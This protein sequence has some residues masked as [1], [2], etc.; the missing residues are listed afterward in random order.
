MRRR[1]LARDYL[2]AILIAALFLRFANTFVLQT[3][4]ISSGLMEDT[5]LIGD[6]LFV[7]RYIYGPASSELEQALL[8]ARPLRRGD[9][10][11]FR[12]PEDPTID[13]VKRC[14]G[15]PGDVVEIEAKHLSINGLPVNDSTYTRFT[16]PQTIPRGADAALN[17]RNSFGP[18]QVPADH[19]FCLGDNRNNSYDSRF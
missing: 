11:I 6:H 16:D 9:V 8:P 1:S 4:Y 12:S 17:H 5:L 19:Y 2:E 3:F 14:V 7:N 18:F 13:V 15:L 10:V